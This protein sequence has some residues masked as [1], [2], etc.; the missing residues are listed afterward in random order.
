MLLAASITLELPPFRGNHAGRNAISVTTQERKGCVMSVPRVRVGEQ[1]NEEDDSIGVRRL[2]GSYVAP[3]SLANENEFNLS[4]G[5][6]P[7]LQW[8]QEVEDEAATQQGVDEDYVVP[9]DEGE[10]RRGAPRG[11]GLFATLQDEGRSAMSWAER[12]EKTLAATVKRDFHSAEDAA[13]ARLAR[14][15]KKLTQ[16]KTYW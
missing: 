11:G 10:E 8:K 6:P 2:F 15:E 13:R 5:V 4:R 3:D 14:V 1:Q 9:D 16:A 7:H 12:K